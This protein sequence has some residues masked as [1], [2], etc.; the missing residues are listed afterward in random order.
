MAVL[1][2][3]VLAVLAANANGMDNIFISS[4]KS[5]IRHVLQ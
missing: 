3:A 2:L 1:L 5:S 4:K